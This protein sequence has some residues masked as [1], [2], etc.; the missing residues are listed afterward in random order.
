MSFLLGINWLFI[1]FLCV[2]FLR[3][4]SVRIVLVVMVVNKIKIVWES[5]GVNSIVF[6][7]W[8]CCFLI[9]FFWNKGRLFFECGLLIFLDEF[10]DGLILDMVVIFWY[11]IY[12][13]CKWF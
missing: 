4:K 7:Y 3:N 6:S 9:V 8:V 1:C 5:E 2:Y 11:C 10:E 13:Y 12:V